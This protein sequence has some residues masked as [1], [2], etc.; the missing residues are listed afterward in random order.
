MDSPEGFEDFLEVI[1]KLSD[2]F[3]GVEPKRQ[4]IIQELVSAKGVIFPAKLFHYTN[5]KGV[6]GI[7]ESNNLWATGFQSLN[8]STEL[9]HGARLL[10]DELE[11]YGNESGG[12]NS[13]L[14][15]KLANYYREHGDAYRS[16]FETYI[17]SFSEDPDVLSQWRA[18][19]EQAKGCC[20]EFDFSDSRL[21]TIVSETTPWALEIVPVIYDESLQRKLIKSGIERMLGYLDSTEWTVQKLANS[22]EME[23]GVVLGLLM[24]SFEPFV[25]AFK[26]VG[27]SEEKEWR[28]VASCASNLTDPKKKERETNS[29]PASYL[30]CIFVQGD[31]VNL[32]QRELLPITGIKYGPLAKE[33]TIEDIKK[34]LVLH[35]YENQ[36][37]HSK[38]EI[39][40]K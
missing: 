36:I 27:F 11:R 29:G 3:A 37:A 40:L 25:T 19:S 12:D 5:S 23:Q 13:V 10:V 24:H 6:S 38:S 4:E 20:V 8:D 7:V 18:Y 32:W 31:D 14:L 1:S 26:H 34:Q 16:F 30:E 28:A 15:H 2:V 9:V 17:I 21:F 39:P 22:S 35:G 33:D